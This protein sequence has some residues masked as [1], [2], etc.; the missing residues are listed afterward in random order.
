MLSKLFSFFNKKQKKYQDFSSV[1]YLLQCI[2]ELK[3][4][5][6]YNKRDLKHFESL[7]GFILLKKEKAL[8]NEFLEAFLMNLQDKYN[9]KF[10][11]SKLLLST[12]KT[13]NI[14]LISTATS[15]ISRSH[16]YFDK[17]DKAFQINI[18]K[19]FFI[20]I[21]SCKGNNAE[22]M[23]ILLNDY[24]FSWGSKTFSFENLLKPTI[25]LSIKNKDYK[26]YY[27]IMDSLNLKANYY[28]GEIIK[29]ASMIALENN[30]L[31][32]FN[33]GYS[34]DI[35]SKRENTRSHNSAQFLLESF[36]I[37]I[38]EHKFQAASNILSIKKELDN[39]Y[40]IF[41]SD[42]QYSSNN[43]NVISAIETLIKYD[44]PLLK[45]FINHIKEEINQ[46][47]FSDKMLNKFSYKYLCILNNS[48]L[49]FSDKVD[50]FSKY[51]FMLKNDMLVKFFKNFYSIDNQFLNY[52][53][54]NLNTE[55]KNKI[56][57]LI[58][59]LKIKNKINSF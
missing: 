20:T 48:N 57:S 14:Y 29:E 7:Y 37:F 6:S 56:N 53:Y 8:V 55:K 31:D 27:S 17:E 46:Q 22:L 42:E 44:K 36:F 12:F 23:K 51:Y 18:H 19:M 11:I 30:Y 13:K 43:D 10:F 38:K 34:F 49:D 9:Y 35:Y 54:K 26:L 32:F 2:N 40:F 59:S 33:N 45:I 47:F 4:Y 41:L 3:K 50:L 28:N 25:Y 16:I 5:S 21:N 58:E 52:I 1:S 15:V 24:C 39:F